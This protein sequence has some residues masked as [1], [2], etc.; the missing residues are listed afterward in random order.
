MLSS[1]GEGYKE[2]SKTVRNANDVDYTFSG[3]SPSNHK[4]HQIPLKFTQ[5]YAKWYTDARLAAAITP[6]YSVAHVLSAY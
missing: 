2:N 4:R 6:A 3:H 1:R 5:Y